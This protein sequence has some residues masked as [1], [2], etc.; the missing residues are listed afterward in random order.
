[1]SLQRR[2]MGFT[3]VELLVVIAII[4]VLV[5]LLLPAVQAA[6][7]AARR[8]QCVNKMK[9]LALANHNYESARRVF[10]P[11]HTHPRTPPCSGSNLNGGPPW[12]VFILPYI[13]GGAIQDQFD[14]S[15]PMTSSKNVAGSPQN[16]AVWLQSNPNYQCPS[17]P[18]SRSDINNSNY[19]GVQGGG[20]T[21]TLCTTVSGLRVFHKNGVLYH[22]SKTR[23]KDITDG[24]SKTFLLG[25][26]KYQRTID[27]SATAYLGWASSGLANGSS[28]RPGVLAAAIDPINSEAASGSD[29][30]ADLLDVYT[31]LF[32]SFH[33]G[34]CHFA[35]CDGS[36]HFISEDIDHNTY[37]I[38]AQRADGNS[39]GEY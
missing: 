7:E 24:M 38:L 33:A 21:N 36:V 22:N 8:N 39:I 17:N 25:E 29:P 13:E 31:R 15:A 23:T 2:K 34:G 19:F 18:D 26:T 30:D 35:M 4:G 32:G 11:G 27:S 12:S 3:L 9:Q 37:E 1:V 28:G 16:D 5:A 20:S 6:R 10:P 14:L